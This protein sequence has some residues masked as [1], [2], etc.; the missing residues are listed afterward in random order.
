MELSDRRAELRRA[1]PVCAWAAS[2]AF[3]FNDSGAVPAIFILAAYI[4]TILYHLFSE[5]AQLPSELT[6]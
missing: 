6:A 3:L 1:F 4:A 2:A 5:S